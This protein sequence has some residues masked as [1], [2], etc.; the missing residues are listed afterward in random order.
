LNKK[1]TSSLW[2]NQCSLQN[3]I[4]VV[5]GAP[6]YFLKAGVARSDD[7]NNP[8]V[9]KKVRRV[10]KLTEARESNMRA[11]VCDVCDDVSSCAA[12]TETCFTE[13]GICAAVREDTMLTSQSCGT[14]QQSQLFVE[15]V[16]EIVED[17]ETETC[18]DSEC[19]STS[20]IAEKPEYHPEPP[21]TT[22]S[23]TATSMTTS[24]TTTVT[25]TTTSGSKIMISSIVS[26]L[27]VF[28]FV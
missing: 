18:I 20:E 2:Y 22:T 8:I 11:L 19:F 5:G 27:A 26:I 12:P 16:D 14:Y 28:I 13:Y 15:G 25:T 23:T 4:R 9:N 3:G 21:T 6:L 7:P 24:S 10:T 17:F 1:Q